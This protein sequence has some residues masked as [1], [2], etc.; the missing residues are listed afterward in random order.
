M[1]RVFVPISM[2]QQTV[3][4]LAG[5]PDVD[6]YVE[7]G[8]RRAKESVGPIQQS[9]V[10]LAQSS[11]AGTAATDGAKTTA[12]WFDLTN[13]DALDEADMEAVWALGASPD[14]GDVQVGTGVG[15][16]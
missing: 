15:M 11:E 12:E 9:K 7:H 5:Y 3:D 16:E 14:T 13:G 4:V 6:I 2:L 1:V 10:L 8:T